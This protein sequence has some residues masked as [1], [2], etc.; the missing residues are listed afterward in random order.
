MFTVA[1]GGHCSMEGV[2]MGDRVLSTPEAKAAIQQIQSLING[3]LADEIGKLDGQGK[4]LSD[5]NVWDGA[6]ARTFRQDTWPQTKSALEKA[7]TEL[8]ELQSHLA[9]I[10][11]NIMH[12]G[13]SS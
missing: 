3:G 5:P 10:S 9:Q 11:Q 6:L 7:K 4:I 8:E 12:A 1:T 2:V 13:G